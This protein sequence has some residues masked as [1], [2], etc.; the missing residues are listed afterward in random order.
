[1]TGRM[2]RFFEAA[3]KNGKTLQ[4]LQNLKELSFA[5]QREQITALAAEVGV[6]RR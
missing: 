1:M 3:V 5:E 2:K 6:T 4:K